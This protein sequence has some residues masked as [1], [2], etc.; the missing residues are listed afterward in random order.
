MVKKTSDRLH[1]STPESVDG[2][3]YRKCT[4]STD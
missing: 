2:V 1:P 4:V 3:I